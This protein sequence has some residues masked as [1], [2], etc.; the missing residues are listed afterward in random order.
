MTAAARKDRFWLDRIADGRELA[1]VRHTL[2][3][4]LISSAFLLK[5]HKTQMF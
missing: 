4:D 1:E 5:K 3:P 2:Q